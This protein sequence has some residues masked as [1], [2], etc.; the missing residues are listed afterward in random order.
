MVQQASLFT[1]KGNSLT[2]TTVASHAVTKFAIP[3]S[4]QSRVTP[5]SAETLSG[6]QQQL[7]KNVVT[8]GALPVAEIITAS[9]NE[10][11]ITPEQSPHK[12]ASPT[13]TQGAQHSVDTASTQTKPSPTDENIKGSQVHQAII[14]LSRTLLSQTGSTQ[15]A[16][17]QLLVNAGR[18]R[19]ASSPQV[20]TQSPVNRTPQE[21]LTSQALSLETLSPQTKQF[22][23]NIGQAL[24]PL[25]NNAPVPLSNPHESKGKES[26]SLN[27]PSDAATSTKRDKKPDALAVQNAKAET[28]SLPQSE[29]Y[30]K[31]AWSQLTGALLANNKAIGNFTINTAT[32]SVNTTQQDTGANKPTRN[33]DFDAAT[34]A[35]EKDKGAP[36]ASSPASHADT[37]NGQTGSPQLL[38]AR[39]QSLLTTPALATTPL[40][41]TNPVT[42]SSFVQGLVALLQVSLAGRAMQRQPSLAALVERPDSIVSKTLATNGVPTGNSSKVA[43]DV[44]SLDARS[45]LLANLKTLL[46]NHQQNKVSQVDAR[47]QGQDSFYYVLPSLAQQTAAPELLIQR[48]PDRH[49]KEQSATGKH[50]QWN[51]T[52]KLEVGEIGEVLAKS[53][54]KGETITLDLYVSN[55]VLLSRVGDTLPYLKQRLS[56]LGLEVESSS[57]QRGNIP[58]T[59]NTRPHQIFET[60]V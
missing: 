46:A 21:A 13:S 52:M 18:A 2:S 54:I 47:V 31:R 51:I 14:A 24:T 59:L 48:E 44:A 1:L 60:R 30:V 36:K 9:K 55:P 10:R 15:Q 3:S 32:Q 7:L 27:G 33:Q 35:L 6:N 23:N 37:T 50:R 49:H 17:S 16:L 19:D 42:S 40:M 56:E 26:A 53:K 45:N 43:Q 39:I 34:L 8:A 28:A 57:F 41:L 25:N 20:A 58:S 5:L 29:N 11:A 22:L 38:S 4:L 12:S